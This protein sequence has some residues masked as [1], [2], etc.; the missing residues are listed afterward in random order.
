MDFQM[1]IVHRALLR[2]DELCRVRFLPVRAV[3][4]VR[5]HLPLLHQGS[6]K[7]RCN[8]LPAD[9]ALHHADRL[10]LS[11]PSSQLRLACPMGATGDAVRQ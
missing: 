4:E 8:H 3:R 11:L 9:V 6:W 7:E 10:G 5:F 2:D 1:Q